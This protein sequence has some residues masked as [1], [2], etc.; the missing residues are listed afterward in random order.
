MRMMGPALLVVGVFSGVC[1]GAGETRPGTMPGKIGYSL[2]HQI[3]SDLRL[4]GAE[5]DLDSL[6]QGVS[7]G[8]AGAAPALSAEEVS[9][10]LL[11]L[12]K[13]VTIAKQE[14]KRA[15]AELYRGE[16]REFLAENAKKEGVV[17]LPSGL[18]YEVLR[19]G[20]G[21][22]PGPTDEVTV[23][24]RGTLIDGT[25]FGSS[26]AAGAPEKYRVNGVIRGWAEA[27]Q[28]M[29]EGAKWRLFIPPDLAFGERG[30]LA[31]RAVIYEIELI[32]VAPGE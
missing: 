6:R 5:V 12:K 21:K 7:D 32:A 13:S 4:Q 8:L 18:Q 29:R 23:H 25:E 15:A 26:Y 27:L 2:G 11:D 1:F 24:Y 19:P 30:P 16:G 10:V 9:A 31:D 22:T 3:G 20:D 17:Q 28:R 14:E